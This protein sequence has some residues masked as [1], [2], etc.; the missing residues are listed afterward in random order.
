MNKIILFAVLAVVTFAIGCGDG[1]PPLAPVKGK[2]TF[3]GKPYAKGI[4]TFSPV[5]GGPS[6][7]SATDDNGDYEL[8]TS[9]KK[10]AVIGKHKVSVTTII[11]PP[12]DSGPPPGATSSDDPGYTAFGNPSDYKKVESAKKEPIPAKF[13]KDTTLEKEVSSGSN[14]IDLELK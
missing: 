5:D 13:N 8:W 14:S 11:E 1:G 7:T 2:V 9:G 6:A 3:Y 4:V 10:G 12:K